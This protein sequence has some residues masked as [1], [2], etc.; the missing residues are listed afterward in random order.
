MPPYRLSVCVDFYDDLLTGPFDRDRLRALL[1]IFRDARMDRVYWIY[2]HRRDG[3]AYLRRTP[4]ARIAENAE[5]TYRAVGEFLPAAVEAAHA[6]GMELYAVYKPFDLAHND[7]F[8]FGSAAARTYGLGMQSL[9]GEIFC[10]LRSMVPLAHLR[11]KRRTDD[12]PPDLDRRV[13]GRVRF[14][15]LDAAPTRVRREH[16]RLAVSRD[17]GAFLPY[18]AP[19]EFIDAI[20]NGRRVVTL[21]GLRI[22]EPFFAVETPFRDGGATLRNTLADLARVYDT[23]GRELPFTYGLLSRADRYGPDVA[24]DARLALW[25]ELAREGYCFNLPDFHA[26]ER[27]HTAL[28]GRRGYLAFARGKELFIAGALAPAYDEVHDF[29]LSHVRECLDAGVDGVDLRD[30]QHNRSLAWEEYGFEPPVVEEYRRRHGE[31]D[32]ARFDREKQVEIISERYT[33]F[34]RKASRLIRGRGKRVQMHVNLLGRRYMGMKWDWERWIAEGLTDEITLKNLWPGDEAQLDRIAPLA[35]ARGIAL[36]SCPWLV[37][38]KGPDAARKL[39]QGLRAAFL[40]GRESGFILYESGYLAEVGDGMRP[41]IL[42]P[43]ILDAL[44]AS[45]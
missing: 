39:A 29:W 27:P 40:G 24:A 7:T 18:S 8:P 25:P 23:E 6:L 14:T 16:I 21:A 38:Q 19:F 2:T 36:H 13:I 41:R 33:D 34:Y 35:K 1:R 9:S 32:P 12:L 37:D 22:A 3:A 4:F 43:E 20:E 26:P 31:D 11:M 42:V 28:D 30:A 45:A 10:G 5:A 15:G 44:S 17:N